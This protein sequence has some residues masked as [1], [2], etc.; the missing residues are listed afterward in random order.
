MLAEQQ[1]LLTTVLMLW[2]ELAEHLDLVQ[3]LQP[4]VVEVAPTI[5]QH[6]AAQVILQVQGAVAI[7]AEVVVEEEEEALVRIPVEEAVA[8][9]VP[10]I[11]HLDFNTRL[12]LV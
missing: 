4:V 6:Q 10:V 3:F 12:A 5:Q 9:V 7:P 1:L 2:E 8:L 11:D